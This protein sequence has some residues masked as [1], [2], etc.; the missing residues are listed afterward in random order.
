MSWRR[1]RRRRIRSVELVGHDEGSPEQQSCREV[2]DEEAR[3]GEIAEQ[4]DREDLTAGLLAEPGR[5]KC[6]QALELAWNLRYLAQPNAYPHLVQPIAN[7]LH[8]P[9]THPALPHSP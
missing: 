1:R 8:F 5:E 9:T 6:R 2:S 3:Y 4:A 7:L